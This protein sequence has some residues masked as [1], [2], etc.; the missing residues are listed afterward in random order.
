MDSFFTSNI[1]NSSIN[2]SSKGAMDSSF[3]NSSTTM[4]M[5][6]E[7]QQGW[8]MAPFQVLLIS[9]LLSIFGLVLNI[10]HV[11]ILTKLPVGKYLG[12]KNNRKLL[13]SVAALDITVSVVKIPLDY[14]E[15][16]YFLDGIT[17]LCAFT[18]VMGYCSHMATEGMLLIG[19]ID[20]LII[21]KNP[22]E[23]TSTFLARH[24]GKIITIPIIWTFGYVAV[25]LGFYHKKILAPRGFSIC[26]MDMSDLKPLNVL[27]TLN[28]LGPVFMTFVIYY[29][30]CCV[31]RKADL[32][33]Q[34]AGSIRFSYRVATYIFTT[35][36][37]TLVAWIFAPLNLILSGIGRFNITIYYMG[38]LMVFTSSIIH[39][40]MYGIAVP[41]YRN[42]IKKVLGCEKPRRG[43]NNA[44]A[45]AGHIQDDSST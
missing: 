33:R 43:Y 36:A 21:I 14:H 11:I 29:I 4:N 40:I 22:A 23:Y 15:V 28:I 18:A 31:M 32:S 25:F 26:Y 27:T 3:I 38:P 39:P 16:Q 17:W 19:C 45:P 42:Y 35:M 34:H 2:T 30:I 44:V 24:L 5:T 20:R 10:P 1:A 13:L 41:S 9:N 37:V 6:T 12:A 7:E 8:R